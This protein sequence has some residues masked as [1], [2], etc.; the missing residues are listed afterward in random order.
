MFH[1]SPCERIKAEDVDVSLYSNNN[2][3]TSDGTTLYPRQR[4]SIFEMQTH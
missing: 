3:S 1:F 2:Y 4:N